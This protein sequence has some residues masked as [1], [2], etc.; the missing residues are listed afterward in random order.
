MRINKTSL[1][2]YVY[3]FIFTSIISYFIANRDLNNVADTMNYANNFLTKTNMDFRYEVLF[4]LVTY[5]IRL[6][7]DNFIFYFFILNFILNFLILKIS[8]MFSRIFGFNQLIFFIFFF[9]LFIFSSWYYSASTNGLRQGLALAICYYSFVGYLVY[10]SKIR[11]SF[12]FL[13]SCFFHYSNFLILPFIFL[14]RLSLNK[15]FFLL[16][17][18]GLFYYLNFNEF[19]VQKFSLILSLPI[20]NEIKNYSE[21]GISSYRYGFQLDLFLYTMFF[22]YMYWFCNKFIIKDNLFF[23]NVIKFFYILVFPYFIFGFAGYSNRYGFMCW[24]FSIFVNC[25]IF[26]VLLLKGKRALFENFFLILLILS[27]MFF[28]YR[29]V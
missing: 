13:A 12:L 26:Y 8:I 29:Y 6:F 28:Y 17:L 10:E 14:Y 7:T 15:I 25:L 1:Y 4:D 18:L 20:Y 23:S 11:A 24:F 9:N 5:F 21:D 27:L 16:N 22:V 2:L 19:L 3:F